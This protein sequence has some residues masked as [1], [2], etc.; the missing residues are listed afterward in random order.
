MSDVLYDKLKDAFEEKFPKHPLLTNVGAP[1]TKS[2][3]K[4]PFWMGSMNKIKPGTKSLITW[5]SKHKSP[6]LISDKLDGVSC[7]YYK[8]KANQRSYILVVMV[9]MGRT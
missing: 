5:F 3:V 1:I 9:N 8:N 7:I 2:K 4:L 6:Y